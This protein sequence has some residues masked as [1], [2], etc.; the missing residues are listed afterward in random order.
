MISKKKCRPTDEAKLLLINLKYYCTLLHHT[1]PIPVVSCIKY[2]LI[3][4]LSSH[5]SGQN[6]YL[7][8]YDTEL[9][10]RL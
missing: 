8:A 1:S 10:P 5:A 3:K 4:N 6:Q 9:R 2:G 7:K